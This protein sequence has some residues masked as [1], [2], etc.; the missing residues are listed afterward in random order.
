MIA[1]VLKLSTTIASV[2]LGREYRTGAGH[3]EWVPVQCS[4][5]Q[6]GAGATDNDIGAMGAVAIAEALKL[7]TTIMSVDLG[8]ECRVAVPADGTH[9]THKNVCVCVCVC[10]CLCVCVCVCMCV[11]VCMCTCICVCVCV[12]MC[13]CVCMGGGIR[14]QDG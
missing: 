5:T 4:F 12:C 10:V 14:H 1:E 11:Y 13:L 2:N 8:S 6:C 7:N 3:T 9:T